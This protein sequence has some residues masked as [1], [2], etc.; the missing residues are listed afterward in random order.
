VRAGGPSDHEARAILRAALAQARTLPARA[1]DGQIVTLDTAAIPGADL[2]RC[3]PDSDQ[4][5]GGRFG[6]FGAGRSDVCRYRV[7][8]P[9]LGPHALALRATR[10]NSDPADRPSGNALVDGPSR[11][12]GPWRWSAPGAAGPARLLAGWT[13][14]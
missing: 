8:P 7:T 6:G 12:V 5:S 4:A 2:A 11:F 9:G 13:G 3:A 14:E 1:P 10:A